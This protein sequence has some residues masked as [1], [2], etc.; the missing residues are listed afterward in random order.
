MITRIKELKEKLRIL[1]L[2]AIEEMKNE[3]N[4]H[5]DIP[6]VSQISS[7]LAVVKFST[8]ASSRTWNLN[9]QYYN[10]SA[11]VE[12]ISQK[13]DQLGSI[14][15]IA[16]YLKSLDK[17]NFHPEILKIAEKIVLEIES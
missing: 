3:L 13:M 12:I 11:Q 9:P 2:Q 4:S 16:K 1:E 15:K 10:L 14:D 8:I 7:T 6:G 17:G 5:P